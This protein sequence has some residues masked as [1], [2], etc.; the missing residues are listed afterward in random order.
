MKPGLRAR[1]WV[2]RPPDWVPSP[3]PTGTRGEGAGYLARTGS[4]AAVGHAGSSQRHTG[5]KLAPRTCVGEP[6]GE[7]VLR[8]WG[9]ERGWLSSKAWLLLS[10]LSLT[11]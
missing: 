4:P 10:I 7:T 3:L 9:G 1:M 11:S 6:D 5:R 2:K 8:I